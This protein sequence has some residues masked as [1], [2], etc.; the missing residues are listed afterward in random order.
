MGS[1][2]EQKKEKREGGVMGLRR[3]YFN[4]LLQ[5]L[6]KITL[7]EM[8]DVLG[9]ALSCGLHW[10]V[11][12]AVKVDTSISVSKQLTGAEREGGGRQGGREG[13]RE[14]EEEAR[15]EGGREEGREGGRGGGKEGGRG[16]KEG[17]RQGGREGGREGEEEA[18]REGEG[19]NSSD[20]HSRTL[21]PFLL[22]DS[23][24]QS[25]LSWQWFAPFLRSE[26]HV[27]PSLPP[28]PSPPTS[29]S[30]PPPTPSPSPSPSPP[31]T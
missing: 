14:G 1:R 10:N 4:V 21:S 26:G 18:R 17:G 5:N 2:R 19:R 13:G 12:I 24:F 22:L 11:L 7:I 30:S 6:S 23:R 27:S 20:F 3:A 25:L 29:S 9:A 15:R 28:V 31:S 8:S 16:G